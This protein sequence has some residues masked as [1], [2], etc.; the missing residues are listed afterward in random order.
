VV[1]GA[2]GLAGETGAVGGLGAGETGAAF[3]S[4]GCFAS[5]TGFVGAGCSA[6]GAVPSGAC[7]AAA[8]TALGAL[9][10]GAIPGEIGGVLGVAGGAGSS[11]TRGSTF[12]FGD[13]AGDDG[14]PGGA[15]FCCSDSAGRG[16][17]CTPSCSLGG[18]KRRGPGG[19]GTAAF[20][21]RTCIDREEPA[22][23]FPTTTPSE[24]HIKATTRNMQIAMMSWPEVNSDASFTGDLDDLALLG[25]SMIDCFLFRALRVFQGAQTF[26]KRPASHLQLLVRKVGVANFNRP[27]ADSIR[28]QN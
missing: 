21:A 14:N 2:V 5:A 10:A 3:S 25:S 24:K 15:G 4:P 6:L 13:A 1:T 7:D 26:H 8:G 22:S 12:P 20:E 28:E 11:E 27:I 9:G 17:F 16:D 19:I 23:Y 18:S